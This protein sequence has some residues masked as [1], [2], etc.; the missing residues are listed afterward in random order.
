METASL[1][2]PALV[3]RFLYIHTHRQTHTHTHTHNGILF[4]HKNEII[5]S[6]AIWM[7]PVIIILGE[8]RQKEKDKYFVI[9]LTCGI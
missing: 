9:S 1:A 2:S 8:I 7:D 5:A 3:G 6:A 4:G